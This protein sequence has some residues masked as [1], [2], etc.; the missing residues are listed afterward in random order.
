MYSRQTRKFRIAV[1]ILVVLAVAVGIAAWYKLYRDVP[2]PA[3]ITADPRDDFLYG[4]IGTERA[5]GIPYWVW[6]VLPR[7]CKDEMHGKEGGY[8]ALG[9]P[10]DEG[11]EMPAGLAKKTVGYVRMA[12]NCALCHAASS[13]PSPEGVRTIVITPRGQTTDIRGLFIFFHQCAQSPH[14][15][16]D[17]IL[18]EIGMVT[19]L[20]LLERMLYRFVLIPRTRRILLGGHRPLLID[21]ELRNHS[22]HPAAPFS[23][24]RRQA[25]ATWLK[26]ELAK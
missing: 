12:G 4:S 7:I 18:S 23:E 15:N 19:K 8:A 5:A 25:L 14:Y 16:A 3:W 26:K 2:Q 9:R 24:E 10:W 1:A 17:E 21:R 13:P 11:I 22:Q 20:S 6:L